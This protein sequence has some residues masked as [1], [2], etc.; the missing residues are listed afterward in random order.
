MSMETL[1]SNKP[2]HT[3]K[4]TDDYCQYIGQFTGQRMTRDGHEW[5]PVWDFYLHGYP[6]YE[7]GRRLFGEAGD[8][9]RQELSVH[10]GGYGLPWAGMPGRWFSAAFAAAL[11]SL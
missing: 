5:K 3:H 8:G 2:V 4:C 11:N 10:D 6:L 7:K 9:F 1:N